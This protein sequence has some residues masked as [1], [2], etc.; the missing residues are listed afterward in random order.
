MRLDPLTEDP[1][2]TEGVATAIPC[3]V[4][5]CGGF[6]VKRRGRCGRF[7][8]C[9]NFPLCTATMNECDGD[10]RVGEAVYGVTDDCPDVRWDQ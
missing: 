3:Y 5:R 2:P 8:G 1:H 4:N 9:T 7:Y 10:K 6:L